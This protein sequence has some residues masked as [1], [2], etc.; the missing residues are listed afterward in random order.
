TGGGGRCPPPQLMSH[1]IKRSS[2][3]CR[4]QTKGLAT[5]EKLNLAKRRYQA[6]SKA[7]TTADDMMQSSIALIQAQS[8]VT[9]NWK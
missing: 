5:V 8:S 7:I 1:C 4:Q 9:Y 3:N 2:E 6:N